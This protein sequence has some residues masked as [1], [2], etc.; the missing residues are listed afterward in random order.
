M[1]FSN[2]K[3]NSGNIAAIQEKLAAFGNKSFN[4]DSADFWNLTVDKAGNG[5]ATIRFLPASEGDDS[6]IVRYYDH[7]FQRNGKWYIERSLTTFGFENPDPVNEMNK[8]LYDSGI[9]AN[10]KLV[11]GDDTATPKIIGSKRRL[12]FVAN[13]LV[14]KDSG[15]PENEGKV[16]KYRFGKKIFDMIAGAQKPEFADLEAFDPF[17]FWKGR[18]LTLRA[19]KNAGGQRTYDAS[20][21]S[22]AAEPLFGGDDDRLEAL[23]NK[24]FKLSD[25]IDRS[26]PKY[27]T[28]EDLKKRL[29]YVLGSSRPAPKT[30]AGRVSEDDEVEVATPARK[31]RQAPQPKVAEDTPSWDEGEDNMKFF[32]GLLDDE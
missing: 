9:E 15:K 2:L 3:R 12:N 27:K 21:F 1:S 10:K 4:D 32:N 8:A 26:G 14:I 20:S 25:E 31:P 7:S 22:S 19:K 29:D 28:Y 24:Q 30:A 11:Q 18:N 17:D 23:Y 6:P 16:F 13:I 5:S